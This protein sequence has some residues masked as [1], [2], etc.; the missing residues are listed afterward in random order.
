MFKLDNSK[1]LTFTT[2]DLKE[3]YEPIITKYGFEYEAYLDKD[4]KGLIW[5][6]LYKGEENLDNLWPTMV[7]REAHIDLYPS[8]EE[9][10]YFSTSLWWEDLFT[11]GFMIGANRKEFTDESG[12]EVE[13]LIELMEEAK[14]E[15][16]DILEK[17]RQQLAAKLL[18]IRDRLIIEADTIYCKNE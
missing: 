1:V 15:V 14:R 5:T 10:T 7:I 8:L 12:D 13:V 16:N 3:V 17:C 11:P 2:E 18:E 6:K 4:K 9:A